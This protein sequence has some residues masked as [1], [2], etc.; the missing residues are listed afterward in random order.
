[1][2]RFHLLHFWFRR[3]LAVGLLGGLGLLGSGCSQMSFYSQ[4]V[5]GQV[6]IWARQTSVEKIL[7]RRETPPE[8][9]RQLELARRL[10]VFAETELGLKSGGSYQRYADLGRDYV[11]WT[12]TAAPEFS[13]EPKEWWYPVVGRLGYRGYF[14]K[15]AAEKLARQLRSEGWDVSVGGVV[16]YSTLGWFSDPLLNTYLFDPEE[17]LADLI[18][19]ELAHRRL[20]VPGDTD[21]NEAFATAVAAEGVRRWFERAGDADRLQQLQSRWNRDA[22]VRRVLLDGRARL[23]ALYANGGAPAA[24]RSAKAAE[25]A[26]IEAALG[27]LA[28]E[29][30]GPT[31][32]EGWLNPPWNN[33]R[34]NDVAT[35]H[36]LVPRF[37]ALL[38]ECGG[39][40]EAWYRRVEAI[41]RLESAERR[42][43][44]PGS[45]AGPQRLA[46]E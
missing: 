41:G 46:R 29:L 33:A 26:R 24:L 7:A 21:F 43:V 25:L 20:F 16:A 3:W 37:E 5:S 17:D 15:E 14:Q 11:S 45:D 42:T 38:R 36:E 2:A 19:H 23:E 8:L 32:A 13:L 34:L 18:F 9:R 10:T 6:R 39:D 35:Y 12:V 28:A 44:L 40:L 22:R 31:S 4:A 27:S 30:G 1:M